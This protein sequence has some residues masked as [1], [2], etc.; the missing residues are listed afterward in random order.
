[1]DNP[2][3][4][5]A[6]INR[7]LACYPQGS[8]TDPEMSLRNY[9]TAVSDYAIAD[10]TSAVDAFIK[11]TAPGVNPSFLPPP[12]ALGAECRR[13]VNLRAEEAQRTRDRRPRLPKPDVPR[14]AE[15]R[16]R[17]AAVV[18]ECVAILAN[19]DTSNPESERGRKSIL[20]RTNE[21]FDRERG[22]TVGDPEGDEAAA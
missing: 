8:A 2:E 12:P 1:M 18:D 21:R 19:P 22:Y 11:G 5:L 17:F 20:E 16:A 6:E 4:K 13:Q 7:L 9:L 3:A 10:V 15:S 14:T